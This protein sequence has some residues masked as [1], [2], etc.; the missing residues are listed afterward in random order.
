ML[1]LL[2]SARSTL[3]LALLAA[4]AAPARSTQEA[5]APKVT[6]DAAI[7]WFLPADFDGAVARAR[8]DQ[9]LILIKGVSF[10]IDKEGASCA[11]AGTW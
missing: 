5:A 11:T 8:A 6:D 1:T 2:L 9:R 3:A 4:T 10:G 7:E